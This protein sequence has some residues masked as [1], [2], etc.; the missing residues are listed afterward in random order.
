MIRSAP[1][2]TVL[3]LLP[4]ALAGQGMTVTT[5]AAADG[6]LPGAPALVGISATRWTGAVGVRL[7]GAMDVESSPIA[8]LFGQ[9]RENTVQAWQGDLDLIFDMGRVGL[10]PKNVDPRVFAGFG[11]HGRR[12][13]EVST[14][15]IPVWS[16]GGGAALPVTRWLAFDLEARYRMPHESDASALPIG[17]GGGWEMR[18][19]LAFRFGG[20]RAAARRSAAPRAPA[21]TVYRGA[22][23][24]DASAASVARSA[25]LTAE[26]Y[27]GSRYVWGGNSPAEGFDCSGFVRYVFAAQ[28]IQ[29]PRV[30]TDQA[31]AG[32]RLPN[33][34]DALAPGDLMFYA[35]RDGVINHVAIYAGGG[36]IIH[37]SSSGQGVRYDDLNSQRGR[38]YATRMV[39]A[40]RVIPDG[41]A[42]RLR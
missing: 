3:A 36:R 13:T 34:I 2:V 19:G 28:G 32:Q 6:G 4:T 17:V 39:A 21:G 29:L 20:A 10:R 15:T 41:G 8:P 30:S 11:V 25:V 1:L 9:S 27:V 42:L 24:R 22:A 38:Y 16:Y 14:A 18:G 33:R 5:F 26:R 37:A 7:G 23:T 12:Q 35:G 31:R 40:R